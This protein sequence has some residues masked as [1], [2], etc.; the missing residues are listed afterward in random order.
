LRLTAFA[1]EAPAVLPLLN[2][3]EFADAAIPV[4]STSGVPVIVRFVF[5]AQ[6]QPFPVAVPVATNLPEPNAMDRVLLLLL[7]TVEHVNT[8]PARSSAPFVSVIVPVVVSAPPSVQPPPTPSNVIA[9]ARDTP[10]VVIVLPVDVAPNVIAPVYVRVSPAAGSDKLP[11]MAS[12]PEP[13]SVSVPPLIVKSTNVEAATVTVPPPELA[14]KT[15][16]SVA[17]HG[18]APDAPPVDA[19]MWVVP[20]LFSVPVPP[21][22]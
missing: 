17:V 9:L 21:T 2:V 13:A 10:F 18:P 3:R 19:A 16:L 22:Q 12:A 6:L 7:L 5:V 20:V 14:S 11:L 15:M 1:A 8:N 4:N